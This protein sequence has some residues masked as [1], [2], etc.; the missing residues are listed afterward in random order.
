MKDMV[1]NTLKEFFKNLL[2]RSNI[3]IWL[4]MYS[5]IKTQSITSCI[6]PSGDLLSLG[7]TSQI[8]RV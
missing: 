2:K 8:L 7:A 3:Q 5:V 6:P 1:N 4:V